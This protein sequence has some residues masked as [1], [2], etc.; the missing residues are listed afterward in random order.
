MARAMSAWGERNPNATRVMR[1]ILVFMANLPGS[2][3]VLAQVGDQCR[4]VRMSSVAR[5]GETLA[6]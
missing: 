4:I 5:F 1:R 6:E 3:T 2:G